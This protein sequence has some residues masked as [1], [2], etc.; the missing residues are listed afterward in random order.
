MT[1][2]EVV[3]QHDGKEFKFIVNAI[4]YKD[5][6]DQVVFYINQN[7]ECVWNDDSKI[8]GFCNIEEEYDYKEVYCMMES[9]THI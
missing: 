9:M 7:H 5:I 1:T 8:T 6:E 2:Q 3:G 4:G